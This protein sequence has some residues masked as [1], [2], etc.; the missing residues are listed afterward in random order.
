[1][2]DECEPDCN[3]NGIP[4]GCDIVS[5]FSTDCDG[6]WRPDECQLDPDCNGNGIPDGCDVAGGGSQ[7]CDANAVP[8]EC[9]ED[10]DGDGMIDVCDPDIDGDGVDNGDDECA[11]T[12]LGVPVQADG[13]PIGDTNGDCEVSLIDYGRFNDCIISGG[14]AVPGPTPSCENLFD[15]DGD[16]HIDLADFAGIA[17]LFVVQGSGV[18]GPGN[19]DC[20]EAN[21][22]PG[23][24]D[25]F[26]C[27]AVC[28]LDPFCCDVAWD[29]ICAALAAVVCG[30]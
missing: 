19:G 18:C 5:G 2:P 24:D 10:F 6:S 13:R 11:F 30:G 21:G 29:E 4:D 23:C 12:P 17:N 15:Y 26:C 25:T 22:T 3:G 27:I 16:G 20:F 1:M 9:Q 28:N 14:P 7:D 8:D